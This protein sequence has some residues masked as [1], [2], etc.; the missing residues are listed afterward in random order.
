MAEIF[1]FITFTKGLAQENKKNPGGLKSIKNAADSVHTDT[2]AADSVAIYADSL[3]LKDTA[4]RD[5]IAE[6]NMEDS[7]GIR[8]SKNALP[9]IVTAEAADSAVIDMH[10]NRFYL[11]GKA[12]VNYEDMQLNAGIVS[13]SQAENIVTAAPSQDSAEAAQGRPSFAQGQEKFTY[14]SLQYNFKSKRAIVRNTRSQYGEGFVYSEQVKRNPD[15]S[16]YGL[17]NVYTTCALDT[18]HFGITARKIKVIPGRVVAS[19]PANIAIQNVPTPLFLPF[20]LFP[21]TQGHRSGFILPT[22]TIEEVRGLGLLNGGYY[23]YLNDYVDLAVQSNIYSKGSWSAG[24]LSN[25]VNKYHYSGTLNFN[26]AY[27]KTGESYDP[28]GSIQKDFRVQWTHRSDPKSRPGVSF[29]AAVEAGTSTYNAFNTYSVNQILQNQY[30]S[31]I[32]YTKAWQNKPYSLTIA[33]RHSQNTQTRRVDVTLPEISFFMAQFNPFQRKNSVGTHWYDKIT[34]SYTFNAVNQTSFYDS[35]FS[36]DKLALTDFNNGMVHTIPI[37]ATYNVL[38]HLNMSFNVNYKEY[39]LTRRMYKFYDYQQDRLD[40]NMYHGFFAAR[41][42]NAGINFNTR[43]Y[44]MKMFKHGKIAGIR[45]VLIPSAGLNYTPD[46]AAYPF[47]YGYQTRLDRNGALQY[48]SVYEGNVPSIPSTQ[49]GKF[50]SLVNFGIDNQLQV[51]VRTEKDTTGFKNLRLIDNFRIGSAYNLAA[52]SFNWSPISMSFATLL[53]NVI[54][55]TAG[56]NFDPYAFDYEKGIRLKQ[57]MWDAGKGLARFVNATASVGG[58]FHAK[59]KTAPTDKAAGK[60]DEF[61][62]TMQFGRY[63]DYVDFNVP[64]N[65]NIDYRIQVNKSQILRATELPGKKDTVTID[66]SATFGGDCNLTPRWKLA[67]RSGY[68]FTQKQLT[69]TSIDIYRDLHCWEMRLS[70]IPFG[71]NKNFSFTINVKASVLQDLR[72]IRRRDYRDAVN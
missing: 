10:N 62:R 32:A 33:A 5:T 27:N 17:H 59:P 72:L 53:F 70:T 42:F 9:S 11:Y 63:N 58:S 52:D 50:S 69:L 19:G 28:N 68:N 57:T 30:T 13:Y 3:A 38:R 43:I 7:L 56:A 55:M 34:M 49:F 39:W 31:N 2:L 51:K 22:Y 29:N 67:I 64:W 46:Y 20:G 25:Y 35:L 65:L 16:I 37:S 48:Q 1:I 40:T 24:F 36:F 14:D 47:N 23:L 12:K 21:I 41:D 61:K 71:F 18:P 54:N 8:I 45:H 60:T 26:Y 4:R 44:G 6:K 15:Q 66:H